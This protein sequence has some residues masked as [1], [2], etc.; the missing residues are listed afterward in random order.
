MSVLFLKNVKRN[1]GHPRET[2]VDLVET[3]WVL[4]PQEHSVNS[5]VQL[6]NATFE[7]KCW[8]NCLN[9]TMCRP[10]SGERAPRRRIVDPRD[11]RT[12]R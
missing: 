9:F 1:P 3:V 2:C 12:Q 7:A 11:P 6:G 4:E 8:S 5:E 10:E